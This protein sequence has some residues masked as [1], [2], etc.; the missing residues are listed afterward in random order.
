MVTFPV[1]AFNGLC[2]SVKRS[3]VMNQMFWGSLTIGTVTELSQPVIIHFHLGNGITRDYSVTTSGAGLVEVTIPEADN[4]YFLQGITRVWVESLTTHQP[5]IVTVDSVT[6]NMIEI[7]FRWACKLGTSS[8]EFLE[9]FDNPD[10]PI[11]PC[12]Q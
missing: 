1:I 4:E 3:Q 10:C 12:C 5:L 6:A 11:D 9:L 8:T 2:L 7:P